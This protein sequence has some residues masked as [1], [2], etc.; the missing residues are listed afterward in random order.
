MAGTAFTHDSLIQAFER[1]FDHFSARAVAVE[2]LEA[3]GLKKTDAYDAA[4][5]ARI[6]EAVEKTVARPGVILSSFAPAAEEKPAAKAEEKAA[7]KAE[8][9][10]A[11]PAAEAA[12]VAAAPEAEEK[13]VEKKADKKK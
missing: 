7:P 6:A 2:V 8:P 10:A 13:P 3:A 4:A 11:E 1:R 9:K 5:L 12:E